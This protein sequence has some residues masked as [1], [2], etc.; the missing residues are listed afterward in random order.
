MIENGRGETPE[1]RME[2]VTSKKQGENSPLKSYGGKS[3]S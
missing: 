1:K 3:F 2:A